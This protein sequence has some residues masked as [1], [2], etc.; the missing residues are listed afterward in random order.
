M[1]CRDLGPRGPLDDPD[2][3]LERRSFIK[4]LSLT[5]A[6][7]PAGVVLSSSPA[8]AQD[9]KPGLPGG[10]ACVSRARPGR[11]RPEKDACWWIRSS[12]NPI[13]FKPWNRYWSTRLAVVV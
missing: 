6:L 8:A 3:K 12:G 11:C 2:L 5:A 10:T 4:G 7:L 13:G 1:K 9:R